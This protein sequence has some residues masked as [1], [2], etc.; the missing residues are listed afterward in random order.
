MIHTALIA[1]DEDTSRQ[2]LRQALMECWPTLRV[3]A[4]CASGAEAWDA[5][6]EHEPDLCLLD[7]RMP[8]LTGIEVAQRID[9][10]AHVVF[11]VTSADHALAAFDGPVDY[12]LKPI[13]VQQFNRTLERVQL[14]AGSD[15]ANPP[16]LQPRLDRLAD[17]LRKQIPLEVIQTGVGQDA[18]LLA[19][20][21]VVYFEGDARSTRVVLHD[22]E[23]VL[24]TPLRELLPQLD[25]G[26]FRQIARTLIVNRREIAG[27]ARTDAE[28]MVLS[29]HGRDEKLP[30]ARLFQGLFPA[31]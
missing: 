12:V 3:V 19:V 28:H 2:R 6:L 14:R 25:T 13:E 18:R 11:V 24:R 16:D 8:G 30:V 21:D 1:D 4:E 31:P 22:G 23:A 7:V 17:R 20:D 26:T 15:S 29:L 9:G 5:F 10:R 27:A